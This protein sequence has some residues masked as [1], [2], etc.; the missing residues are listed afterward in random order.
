LALDAVFSFSYKPLKYVSFVGIMIASVT[1]VVGAYMIILKFRGDISDVP[2]WTSLVVSTLFLSGI[3]LVAIGVVG[4]YIARIYD[5][6]KKRPEY[7]VRKTIGLNE[8]ESDD[9]YP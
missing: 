5:E 1:F 2:G 3:Q 4:E 7:I 8:G 9:R 6:V